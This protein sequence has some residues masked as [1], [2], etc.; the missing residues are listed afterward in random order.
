MS[1]SRRERDPAAGDSIRRNALFAF[2]AQM[3]GSACTAGLTLYLVRALGPHEFGILAL[4]IGI[5]TLLMLP[6]D[7]GISNSLARFI[8]EHRGQGPVIGALMRDGLRLKLLVSGALS[9]GL[10]ALAGPI[11]SA[12]GSHGLAWP[13]RAMA[14]SIFGQSFMM[15]FTGAFVALGRVSLNLRIVAAES[16]IEAISAATLVAVG[17]GASGAAFGRA[18]GY[19]CAAVVGLMLALRAIGTRNIISSPRVEGGVRRIWSYGWALLVIDGVYNLIAPIGTLLIGTLLGARAV[20]LYSAPTRFV[21]FLHYP[22]YSIASGIAPRLARGEGGEPDVAALLAGVRWTMLIQTVFVAPTVVWARPFA[23]IVLGHGY[24]QSAD[25]LAALAPY[26][27]LTGFAPLLSLSVNY[28]G[29]ARRRVPIAVAALVGSAALD[30][31]LIKWIGLLGPAISS[32][33]TYAF[34]VLA[35][36]WICSRLIEMPIR[37][38]VR[39]LARCVVAACAMGLALAAFGT[40]HLAAWQVVVGGACG[41]AAYVGALLAIR[42]VSVTE[43]RAGL[44]AIGRRLRPGRP[45]GDVRE[46]LAVPY[47]GPAHEPPA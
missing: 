10:F 40:G 37:P 4:A 9:V 35:H 21:T 45:N 2:A 39:D 23:S 3:V 19:G 14:V 29:E 11:S 30:Y 33:V 7:A 28:L 42:A 15:L 43:L 44:D 12:Y 27:L 26:T 6:G 47:P 1:S 16:V 46:P 31:A 32:D 36:F 20:G 22:G 34:W 17:A 24:A 13:L 8:A 18:I 25:V 5:G 38:I 41:L